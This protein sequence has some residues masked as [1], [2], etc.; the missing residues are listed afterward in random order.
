MSANWSDVQ[1][2]ATKKAHD[3]E[4]S[5]LRQ[6]LDHAIAQIERLEKTK[7]AKIIAATIS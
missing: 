3:A 1:R 6:Q 5:A 2:A 7:Q 4:V